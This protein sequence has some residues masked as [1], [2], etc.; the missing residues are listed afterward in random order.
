MPPVRTHFL[1]RVVSGRRTGA[2]WLGLGLVGVVVATAFFVQ[3]P[4]GPGGVVY[5]VLTAIFQLPSGCFTSTR[6][7]T[8]RWLPP[9][10]TR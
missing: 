8:P 3:D 10:T 6:S 5:A 9:C 2:L 4:D 1:D 7:D